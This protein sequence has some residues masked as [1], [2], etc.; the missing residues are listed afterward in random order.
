MQCNGTR[1]R[2]EDR[3]EVHIKHKHKYLAEDRPFAP[4]RAKKR[5][6]PIGG[7]IDVVLQLV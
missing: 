5:D 2:A 6:H 3:H 1:Q 4:H 7:L